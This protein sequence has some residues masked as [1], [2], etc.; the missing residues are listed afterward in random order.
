MEA[1]PYSISKAKNNS[2]HTLVANSTDCQFLHKRLAFKYDSNSHLARI[3]KWG[4]SRHR[5]ILDNS[6]RTK[7]SN[8]NDHHSPII[9]FCN[10]VNLCA[11]KTSIQELGKPESNSKDPPR[12]MQRFSKRCNIQEPTIA[13]ATFF[14]LVS[15]QKRLASKYDIQQSRTG[16]GQ[17]L[18]RTHSKHPPQVR[19]RIQYKVQHPRTPP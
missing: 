2:H 17:S 15:V 16:V 5:R 11:R 19:A 9:E 12:S 13:T 10:H 4:K 8:S 14:L 1:S 7:G 18:S 3:V 6:Q